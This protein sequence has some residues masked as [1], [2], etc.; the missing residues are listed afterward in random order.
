MKSQQMS[1][2]EAAAEGLGDEYESWE[3]GFIN[4]QRWIEI[5]F[6]SYPR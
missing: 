4:E 1:A 2:E 6:A 3:Q 5:V